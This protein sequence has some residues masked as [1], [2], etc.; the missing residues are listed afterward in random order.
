M[1]V[2]VSDNFH[3][4]SNKRCELL[5]S[6]EYAFR[7][8][9]YEATPQV[10]ASVHYRLHSQIVPKGC[11][12]V[13]AVSFDGIDFYL[14]TTQLYLNLENT[15]SGTAADYPLR[16]LHSRT[17]HSR[18]RIFFVKNFSLVTKT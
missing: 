5:R 10:L 13:N 17:I 6:Y 14:F 15:E 8:L 7:I 18:Y 2:L 16:F 1:S 3:C 12:G 4:P 11:E 9:V